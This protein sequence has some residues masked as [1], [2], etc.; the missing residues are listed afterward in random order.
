[1][2]AAYATPYACPG[3]RL[4]TEAEWE[5]AARAGTTTGTYNGT[6]TLTDCTNPNPILDPIAWFCG[7]AGSTTHAAG[8][9]AA[10]AW[11][12]Y[13]MLGNVWEWVHD[14]HTTYPGDVSDPWGPA[15]GSYRVVRGG[16]WNYDAQIARAAYRGSGVPSYRSSLLG[17]RPVRSL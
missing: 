7:N 1:M 3:Y 2:A 13:D 8:G 10:N 6:S 16:G 14:W 4:P 12:L 11:G 5:Y 17:F 15:A 9:K